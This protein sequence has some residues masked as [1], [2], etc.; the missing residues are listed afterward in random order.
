MG[1]MH[2]TALSL[3]C[4]HMDKHKSNMY[5]LNWTHLPNVLF[6]TQPS[7]NQSVP[8]ASA[9]HVQM[10]LIT[11]GTKEVFFKCLTLETVSCELV[12]TIP[13]SEFRGCIHLQ[14][15]DLYWNKVIFLATLEGAF[16]LRQS[17]PGD[18][19]QSILNASKHARLEWGLK[20]FWTKSADLTNACSLPSNSSKIHLYFL[21][22]G[23]KKYFKLLKW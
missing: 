13:V 20:H 23:K 10:F 17:C 2:H 4:I 11:C 15:Y 6:L 14:G 5:R 7:D 16:E 18:V 8:A 12:N 19:M 21:L 22:L 9:K 1:W 3:N